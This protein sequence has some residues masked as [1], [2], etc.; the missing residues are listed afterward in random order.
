MG[1]KNRVPRWPSGFAL[2][3]PL[4]FIGTALYQA[5]LKSVAVRNLA[6]WL[7]N[8]A[9]ARGIWV[10]LGQGIPGWLRVTLTG[11]M[12]HTYFIAN[13]HVLSDVILFLRDG[14]YAGK[15]NGRP[16]KMNEYG[17]WQLSENYL[18]Y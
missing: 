8:P 5:Q 12:G 17:I 18:E 15:E 6:R 3:F 10:D 9:K 4:G 13:P 1:K 14:K 16:L 7:D 2:G 11:F